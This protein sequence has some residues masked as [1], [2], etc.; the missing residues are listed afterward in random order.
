M[1]AWRNHTRE[2]RVRKERKGKEEKEDGGTGNS[3]ERNQKNNNREGR[4]MERR[5]KWKEGKG[6]RERR[7]SYRK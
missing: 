6:K 4:W 1:N 7:W 2:S 5:M 3:W